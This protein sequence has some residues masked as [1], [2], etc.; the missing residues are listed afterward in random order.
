MQQVTKNSVLQ[1][2]KPVQ[3]NVLKFDAKRQDYVIQ[4]T[5]LDE[6][7]PSNKNIYFISNFPSLLTT[8]VNAEDE[9]S[10]DHKQPEKVKV[11]LDDSAMTLTRGGGEKVVSYGSSY[12]NTIMNLQKNQKFDQVVS[13]SGLSANHLIKFARG[14]EIREMQYFILPNS[15]DAEKKLSTQRKNKNY[16]NKEV[17]GSALD[18]MTKLDLADDALTKIPPNDSNLGYD[19]EAL[20]KSGKIY[21]VKSQM[22]AKEQMKYWVLILGAI[23]IFAFGSAMNVFMMSFSFSKGGQKGTFYDLKKVYLD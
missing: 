7:F 21:N 19:F 10:F 18:I 2:I 14:R 15:E 12:Y 16:T 4:S 6:I 23:G 3:Y 9:Y 5:P 1:E 11:S 13:I 22:K 20:I 8:H 17:R